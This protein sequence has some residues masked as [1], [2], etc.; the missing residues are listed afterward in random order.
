VPFSSCSN[1]TAGAL[2][3]SHAFTCSAR[4]RIEF[5]FQLA[6]S[7]ASSPSSSPHR[8][9]GDRLTFST[10]SSTRSSSRAAARQAQLLP[11]PHR[12]HNLPLAAAQE[13]AAAHHLSRRKDCPSASFHARV[14]K[15]RPRV[16][17]Y[18]A[19]S[20]AARPVGGRPTAEERRQL[21]FAGWQNLFALLS[22][23]LG[24]MPKFY[25]RHLHD[26]EG[27]NAE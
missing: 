16:G 18:I 8:N 12:S 19:S 6:I 15:E 27:G 23:H 13:C 14:R 20:A 4:A 2:T 17:R 21:S 5:T 10:S 9:P 1:R 25:S 26:Q 22:S 24:W 3:S 7:M 11:H